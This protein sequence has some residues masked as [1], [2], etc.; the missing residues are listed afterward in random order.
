MMVPTMVPTM[1]P[2]MVP[3]HVLCTKFTLSRQLL[4][5]V[6]GVTFVPKPIYGPRELYEMPTLGMWW[7]F[8]KY[9]VTLRLVMIPKIRIIY[10]E[11][12]ITFYRA[13]SKAP[14]VLN[15]ES[16]RIFLI[17]FPPKFYNSWPNKWK[18]PLKLRFWKPQKK[19]TFIFV[20]PSPLNNS[21]FGFEDSMKLEYNT[22][23]TIDLGIMFFW[24]CLVITTEIHHVMKL[25][26][27]VRL[28]ET[29]LKRSICEKYF[30]E[31][32]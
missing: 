20:A 7:H 14:T 5:F 2:T 31:S 17:Q 3:D 8:V 12:A 10:L 21:Y 26:S 1:S 29:P 32:I 4:Y 19:S 27:D 23:E 15:D 6:T 30:F 9:S 18:I 11:W 25:K 16:V 24:I 22:F 13:F 28:S